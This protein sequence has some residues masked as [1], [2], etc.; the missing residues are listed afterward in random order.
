[1]RRIFVLLITSLFCIAFVALVRQVSSAPPP[2]STDYKVKVV[3]FYPSDYTPE[4]R[5]IDAIDPLIGEIQQWY[6]EKIGIGKTFSADP[7]QIVKGSKNT[8]YY[9]GNGI[10]TPILQELG[11]YCG[12]ST[13]WLIVNAVTLPFVGGGTC[14][15]AYSD[16][17]NNGVAMITEDIFDAQFIGQETGYCRNGAPLGAWN[18][19]VENRAGVSAHE[20]GHAFTLPIPRIVVPLRLNTATK[21]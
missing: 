6:G 19:S 20:L 12:G 1:M 16:S 11:A 10:W 4:Q 5:Y 3:Y 8:S 2:Q 13:T 18:C 14:S 7:V 21:Q 15:A 9:V 17:T